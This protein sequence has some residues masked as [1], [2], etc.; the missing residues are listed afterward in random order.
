M[1][2]LIAEEE[3]EV[4]KFRRN[5]F[6]A[7]ALSTSCILAIV[8]LTPIA[9]QALQRI[10]SNLLN[11]AHFC[12][13]RNRD[14][15][16]ETMEMARSRGRDE[17][18]VARTRRQVKG[19]W[20]FGQYIPD[21]SSRN[22]RQQY[23]EAG[24]A[25]D[26]TPA[27]E[28]RR[29]PPG[30]P[31]DNGEDGADGKDGAPGEDGKDGAD[32]V[33]GSDGGYQEGPAAAAEACIRSCPPGPPGPTGP[34]GDKGARGYP[35]ESGEPGTPGKAGAKGNPG[36]AG[37][38]GPPG[39]PGRPGE[40]GENGKTIAGEAPAGPP[41]RQGEMGPPGPPG[42]TG[43][44]GKDGAAG[45][46]GSPGDQGNP[47]PYGK[48][49][50]PGEPGSDGS[51]GEKGSCDHCPPP[52]TPPEDQNQKSAR[53]EW[54]LRRGSRL[55][56]NSVVNRTPPMRARLLHSSCSENGLEFSSTPLSSL[57]GQS[58]RQVARKQPTSRGFRHSLSFAWA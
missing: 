19:T 6:S 38:P 23:A 33:G 30:P 12:Q 9:Y 32:A 13:A 52:R 41:G 35:G 58:R 2:S 22:R 42:P 18:L 14:L 10:H 53:E 39:Y 16:T 43:P 26:G 48:P 5:A 56:K 24:A 4:C 46:K 57:K 7:V 20:L 25:A 51:P 15:W 1:K 21:R 47:G 27:A 44:R 36:P 28:C 40:R 34:P 54:D 49:G 17:E 8:I 29:G 55:Q 3:I 50:Q 31:G 37:P 11:D 45:E